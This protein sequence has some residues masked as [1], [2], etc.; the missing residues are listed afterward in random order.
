LAK[1]GRDR[2]VVTNLALDG[3]AL[4]VV[5]QDLQVAIV[6][7]QDDGLSLHVANLFGDYPLGYLTNDSQ[8]LLDLPYLDFFALDRL[9]LY[10]DLIVVAKEVARAVEV[11]ERSEVRVS[12]VVVEAR[13]ARRTRIRVAELEFRRTQNVPATERTER[14]RCCGDGGD[15][16]DQEECGRGEHG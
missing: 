12:I 9:F 14:D 16:G 3:L 4:D 11:V 8:L 7:R 13:E 15:E 1:L 5:A 6:L 2:L 10:N